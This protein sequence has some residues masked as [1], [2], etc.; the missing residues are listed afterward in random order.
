MFQDDFSLE[1]FA[2]LL[3]LGFGCRHVAAALAA[4]VFFVMP[5]IDRVT[6][7]KKGESDERRQRKISRAR[8]GT[9]ISEARCGAPD[10]GARRGLVDS[11]GLEKRRRFVRSP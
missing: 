7:R 10:A 1:I 3:A 9:P 4:L 8:V 5:M 6:Y 11:I 2:I